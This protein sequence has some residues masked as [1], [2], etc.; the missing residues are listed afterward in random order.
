MVQENTY[1]THITI[2]VD[3]TLQKNRDIVTK[4]WY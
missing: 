4:F 1:Y 3:G 2:Y